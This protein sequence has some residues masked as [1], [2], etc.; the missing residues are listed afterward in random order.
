MQDARVALSQCGASSCSPSQSPSLNSSQADQKATHF[1][2]AATQ[3]LTLRF[4]LVV[5]SA[6]LFV[7]GRRP[8][9]CF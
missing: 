7:T 4:L 1:N 6:L 5:S 2:S 3:T 8:L 9:M